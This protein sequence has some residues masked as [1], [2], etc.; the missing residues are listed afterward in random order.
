[1]FP[2]ALRAIASTSA[3][4]PRGSS[5]SFQHSH[6]HLTGTAPSPSRACFHGNRCIPIAPVSSTGASMDVEIVIG[7]P[8]SLRKKIDAIRI[9]G[10]G[11]LQV[12][13][14]SFIVGA[15][16]FWLCLRNLRWLLILIARSRGTGLMVSAGNVGFCFA[17][18]LW[19]FSF[20][21]FWGGRDYWCWFVF[22]VL[23]SEPWVV[24]A[25][26][27]GVW[28]EKKGFVWVLSSTGDLSDNTYCREGKDYG[29]VVRV[30]LVLPVISSLQFDFGGFSRLLFWF[31]CLSWWYILVKMCFFK[32]LLCI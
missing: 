20:V 8:E 15:V 22:C 28:W 9:A 29:G 21:L 13:H 23:I 16:S 14:C 26:E 30:Q 5:F 4:I 6:K 11:K 3:L 7:D 25:G 24:A 1:M 10:T 19:V 27:P 17:L 18:E 31:S 12:L 2:G 32:W